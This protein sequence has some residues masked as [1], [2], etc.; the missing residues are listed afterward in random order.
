[1][2]SKGPI[3]WQ[4]VPCASIPDVTTIKFN[5]LKF[6]EKLRVAGVPEAHARAEAEALVSAFSEAWIRN[7]LPRRDINR[8]E[9][10][11]LVVKWMMGVGIGGITALILKA[12]FPV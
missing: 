7:P 3:C 9:R 11:L 2:A 12:F 5:T 8:V 10:E 6:V 1:M 4:W